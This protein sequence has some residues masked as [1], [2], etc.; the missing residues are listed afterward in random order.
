MTSDVIINIF[1][2]GIAYRHR[3]NIFNFNNEDVIKQTVQ[4]SVYLNL[5]SVCPLSLGGGSRKWSLF[6]DTQ[7]GPGKYG[8]C[9]E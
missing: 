6:M 4:Y 5:R 9:I 1:R 8:L 2:K 3:K 7:L